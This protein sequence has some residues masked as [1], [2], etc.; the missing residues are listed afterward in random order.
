MKAFAVASLFTLAL[1]VPFE[2]IQR[3]DLPDHTP[4]NIPNF[5]DF[6]ARCG[7]TTISAKDIRNAVSWGVNLQ[8]ADQTV[9][10]NGYPHFFGNGEGF[11]FQ[12]AACNDENQDY[13]IEFPILK[14]DTYDGDPDDAGLY[15]AIYVH[16]PN[17]EPDYEGN[18][19]ATYCGTI[20][21]AGS[22]NSFTGCDV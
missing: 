20:Y 16:D 17:T 4:V 14:G 1:A 2:S 13:R 21:H 11:T 19:T 12:D 3:R 6:D 22:D 5:D 18:P 15:R 10:S 9:G 7:S 8:R